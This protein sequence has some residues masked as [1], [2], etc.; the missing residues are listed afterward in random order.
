MPI[1]S[2]I[3]AKLAAVRQWRWHARAMRAAL[4][5]AALGV[6]LL[7]QDAGGADGGGTEDSAIPAMGGDALGTLW[8]AL[9]P[10][11]P[12]AIAGASCSAEGARRDDL[13]C[14]AAA[15]AGV[16]EHP[17]AELSWGA[18]A[19]VGA[20]RVEE[21][22]GIPSQWRSARVVAGLWRRY[23]LDDHLLLVA[24]PGASWST[25]AAGLGWT[26]P[27]AGLW[28]HRAGPRL[29]W[30]V[31][32]AALFWE[33]RPVALPI[34]GFQCLSGPWTILASPVVVAADRLLSPQASLGAAL[35]LAG[36]SAPLL[37]A[38]LRAEAAVWQARAVA[39]GHWS[40]GTHLSLSAEGG[41]EPVRHL[42]IIARDRPTQDRRLHA[43][44]VASASALWSW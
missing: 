36:D 23:G 32:A 34:A 22:P 16:V 11:L 2:A 38:G 33:G 17:S 10:H 18:G 27:I 41:W 7:G 14:S 8:P 19:M 37:V 35:E 1:Q 39:R 21:G 43:G 28:I 3:H 40:A 26:V 24:A 15:W 5:G 25:P 44:A 30:G 20:D 13:V 29:L 9:E 6:A 42:L 12:H 31:G 4:A